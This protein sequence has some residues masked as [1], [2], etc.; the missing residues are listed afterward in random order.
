M[1]HNQGK[2]GDVPK[3]KPSSVNI[4]YSLGEEIGALAESLKIFAKY[5]VSIG[6]LPPVSGV[7]GVLG[8]T[9]SYHRSSNAFLNAILDFFFFLSGVWASGPKMQYIFKKINKNA[10]DIEV[11]ILWL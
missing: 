3:E 2:E 4:I 6:L 9:R 8:R 11:T 1:T 5:K 7:K 10:R